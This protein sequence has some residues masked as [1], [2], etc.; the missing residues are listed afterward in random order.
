MDKV[1]VITASGEITQENVS[2]DTPGTL[3]FVDLAS[4]EYYLKLTDLAKSKERTLARKV[5]TI[6]RAMNEYENYKV[7]SLIAAACLSANKF[8][9]GS[10]ETA[11]R[12]SHLIDMLDAVKDY[13]D[14]YVLVV[15]GTIDK[16]IILWDWTENKYHSLKDALGDLNIEIV[17]VAASQKVTVDGAVTQ[18][19]GSTKAY[20]IA[21]DS[22][23]GKPV[24][25]VRKRLNEIELLGGV[26]KEEDGERPERLIFAS[27][28]PVSVGTNNTRYLAVGVTG[29]EE[30]AG[31]VVNP[32]ALAEFTRA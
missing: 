16:D 2:A 19:L 31:A 10:G 30:F 5:T 11:F 28:N 23:M 12:Y 15:S 24:L 26:I 27:P 32:Y 22:E 18:V 14:S 25:W 3:T 9:L 4:P 29:Y 20:L 21:R 17:R 6:N 8:S 1:Y 7:I 13:G